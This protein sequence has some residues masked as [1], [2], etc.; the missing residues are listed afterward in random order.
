[1]T[2]LLAIVFFI[3]AFISILHGVMY[4]AVKKTDITQKTTFI[5]QVDGFFAST[6]YAHNRQTGYEKVFRFS[7]FGTTI[8]VQADRQKVKWIHYFMHGFKNGYAISVRSD[9]SITFMDPDDNFYNNQP[10][11]KYR[12]DF[13]KAEKLLDK[14]RKRF[15]PII[16]KKLGE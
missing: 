3:L 7:L 6:E 4:F 5:R 12:E 13:E 9:N 2:V 1:M 10:Y 8:S 16:K 15:A 11:E 14:T